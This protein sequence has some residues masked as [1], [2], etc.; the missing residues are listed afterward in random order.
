MTYK[1]KKEHLGVMLQ[2]LNLKISEVEIVKHY[3]MN[4]EEWVELKK[5]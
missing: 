4:G 1:V 5:K 3:P 2:Y